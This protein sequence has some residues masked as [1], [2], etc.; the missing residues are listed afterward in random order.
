[1]DP[2]LERMVAQQ[3]RQ[4]GGQVRVDSGTPDKSVPNFIV[5]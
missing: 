3:A 1:M 5:R 2:A 4:A